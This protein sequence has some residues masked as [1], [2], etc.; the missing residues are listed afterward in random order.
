MKP[1]NPSRESNCYAPNAS[2]WRP[3]MGGD[4]RAGAGGLR[5][6]L[7]R[8]VHYG[9]SGYKVLMVGSRRKAERTQLL[10]LVVIFTR[11]KHLIISCGT[12]V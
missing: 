12:V 7:I 1:N 6:K 10:C 4:A 3:A 5:G 2:I 11:V 8:W 9:Y